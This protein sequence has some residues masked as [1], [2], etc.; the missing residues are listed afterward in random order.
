[1]A[2]DLLLI[3]SITMLCMLSPGPDMVLVMRNTLIGDRQA[4]LLTSLGVL[5]GN[6]VH[7][8]YCA[9]GVGALI[10]HSVLAYGVLKLAGAGYLI[11]LGVTGFRNAKPDASSDAHAPRGAPVAGHAGSPY[12]QGLLNNLLN[13]KG[14]LF[15]LGVFTQVIAP[16]T[17]PFRAAVLVAT[18]VATSALFWLVFVA[19]LH[20]PAVRDLLARSRQTVERAFGVLLV[21][22]GLRVA[23]Q[24]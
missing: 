15:Y 9:L 18:M 19:T 14:A 10:A 13:P 21:L 6:V 16:G 8:A 1:M 3:V 4:G 11:I 23:A 5:S 7:I 17:P 12:L 22:L 2:T 24:N 20:L